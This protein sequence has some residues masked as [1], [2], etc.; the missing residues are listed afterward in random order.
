MLGVAIEKK[1]TFQKWNV[2]KKLTVFLLEH[3]GALYCMCGGEWVKEAIM[4]ITF[5]LLIKIQ[6]IL[7]LLNLY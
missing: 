7:L 4:F 2:S 1:S 6:K 3:S 5:V